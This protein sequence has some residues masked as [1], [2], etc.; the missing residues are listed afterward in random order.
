M[1]G[2][3]MYIHRDVQ[4]KLVVNKRIVNNCW[5]IGIKIKPEKFNGVLIAT[6][7]SP[8]AK[9]SD[10]IDYIEDIC[11][12]FKNEYNCICVGDF[13][14]GIS[15]NS[16]YSRKFLCAFAGLGMKQYVNEPTRMNEISSTTIDL[17][18][19]NN[20]INPRVIKDL[21]ITDHAVIEFDLELERT[22]NLKR[23]TL[24]RNFNH[25][26]GELFRE[27]LAGEMSELRNITQYGQIR[28]QNK[29][30]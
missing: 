30:F 2:V 25:F 18:F 11:E 8:S 17:L 10:F 13:N 22:K 1:G 29:E 19:C 7:H 21:Q 16:Y 3:M 14:I 27:R 12:N 23:R 15:K 26:N 5:S 6:Y 9:T 24:Q 20:Q 4:Y 28:Y